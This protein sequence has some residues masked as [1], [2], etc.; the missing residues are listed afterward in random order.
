MSQVSPKTSAFFDF[1]KVDLLAVY[2]ETRG[3]YW[4]LKE[5]LQDFWSSDE[6]ENGEVPTVREYLTYTG[7]PEDYEEYEEDEEHE[8]YEEHEELESR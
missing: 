6:D 3:C 4:A 1:Y 8:E 2:K 5:A 7:L